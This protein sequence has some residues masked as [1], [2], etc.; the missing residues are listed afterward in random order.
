MADLKA[1][2][3]AITSFYETNKKPCIPVIAVACE[4]TIYYFKDFNPY[5]K[6]EIPSVTFSVQEA[7]IWHHL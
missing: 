5:L 2:P 4:N 1:K 7:K 3:V 6:F